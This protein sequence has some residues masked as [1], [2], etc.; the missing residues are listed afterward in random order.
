MLLQY[1]AIFFLC[2]VKPPHSSRLH[3]KPPHSSCLHTFY[4]FKLKEVF[5]PSEAFYIFCTYFFGDVF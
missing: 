2:T 5:F 3:V 1:E 4:H